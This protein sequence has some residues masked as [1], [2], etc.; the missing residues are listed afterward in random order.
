MPNR[1]EKKER[2]KK[3]S[4]MRGFFVFLLLLLLFFN[5]TVTSSLEMF[6]WS[7]VSVLHNYLPGLLVNVIGI[8]FFSSSLGGGVLNRCLGRE[9][10]PGRS[11]PD[12]VQDTIL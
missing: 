4:E 1:L 3:S 12:P 6:A 10:R 8:F 9:V 5:L 11:N 7:S 2:K